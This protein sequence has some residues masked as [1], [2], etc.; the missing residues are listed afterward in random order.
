MREVGMSQ[1]HWTRL[2]NKDE[3]AWRDELISLFEE[4]M[5]KILVRSRVIGY[6][7]ISDELNGIIKLEDYRRLFEQLII[8][9]GAK[10]Y[11][12]I[13][14]RANGAKKHL[15]IKAIDP[16]DPYYLFMREYLDSKT[17]TDVRTIAESSK[18]EAR[19]AIAAAVEL[20]LEQGAGE[21]SI[22]AL[23][24]E[25]I[26][27]N[28]RV[29]NEFRAQ[30]IARTEVA[31]LAN[32]ASLLGAQTSDVN[33]KKKWMA[34]IDSRTRLT[35]IQADGDIVEENERFRIG[36]SYMLMPLDSAGSAAE[37]INC[38]CRL[39]YIVE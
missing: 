34:Y 35:H 2:T 26:R 17:A 22:I 10:Y 30:R 27:L 39:F 38:R 15:K 8:P 9:Q 29:A 5:D 19:R 7:A 13:K 18:A 16:D 24:E 37:V 6:K 33:F 25:N 1:N 12:F 21:V 3:R 31:A 36:N 32:R 20:G 28:W 11:D 4:Q 14:T 23:I